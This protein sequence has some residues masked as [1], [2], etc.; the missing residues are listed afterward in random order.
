MRRTKQ[1]AEVLQVLQHAHD[2]PTA[3]SIHAEVRKTMPSVSLATVYRQL[4]ALTDEGR[5]AVVTTDAGPRRYDAAITAHHHV[6][7]SRCG[8]IADVPNL[9][10]EYAR[11]EIERWTGYSVTRLRTNWVGL[12]ADCQAHA[13][14]PSA[15]SIAT[16]T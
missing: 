12:C 1:R 6:V 8:H 11:V 9:I 3:E 14:E 10:G 5:I 4:A 13:E 7:C 15:K 16:G 2:H